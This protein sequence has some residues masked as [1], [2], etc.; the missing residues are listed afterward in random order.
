MFTFT[1]T[2]K[3]IRALAL[4]IVCFCFVTGLRAQTP[5]FK[6][7]A[8]YNGT[9]DAAHINFVQEARVWYPQLASQ[10]G[11]SWESTN[12]WS[13]LSASGLAGYQV[14]MFLDDLPPQAQQAAFQ[15]YM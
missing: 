6:V 11:F 12:D 13:R 2:Q 4:L 8:F 14:I 9:F 5:K 10:N 7:L 15:T 1:K 3:S